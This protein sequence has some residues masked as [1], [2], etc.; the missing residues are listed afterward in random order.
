MTKFAVEITTPDKPYAKIS[1]EMV[2]APGSEGQFAVMKDHISF[3]TSLKKGF[4][5]ISDGNKTLDKIGIK[6]GI[7]KFE[8]NLCLILIDEILEHHEIKEAE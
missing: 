3:L 1:A 8:N 2:V 6:S 4:I 7:L 5:R